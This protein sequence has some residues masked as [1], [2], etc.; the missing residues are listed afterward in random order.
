[1]VRFGLRSAAIILISFLTCFITPLS[2][3]EP[4]EVVVEGI[5]G[6]V[7]KNVREALVLPYGL[8]QG[9]KGGS[10][11]ARTFRAAGG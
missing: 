2:A 8:V 6:D 1:M 10:V 9:R 5:E 11:V 4:I 3:A 7:L